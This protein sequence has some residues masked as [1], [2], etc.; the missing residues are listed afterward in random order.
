MEHVANWRERR[1]RSGVQRLNKE[2]RRHPP[3]R[4]ELLA[5]KL[6]WGNPGYSAGIAYLTHLC[7]AVHE[8]SGG[9]LECGSGLS[10]LVGGMLARQVGRPWIALENHGPSRRRMRRYLAALGL[11]GVSL[12]T[13]PIVSYGGYD[14]YGVPEEIVATID[15]DLVICDGPP[16]HTR[17]GRF[18]LMPAMGARL[19]P[20]CRILLDDAYRPAERNIIRRWR[21]LVDLEVRFLGRPLAYAEIILIT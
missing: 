7:R 5:L 12:V 1:L 9:I 15:I 20:G 17:G 19:R 10:T 21:D 2:G 13:A 16:W 8:N 18:G 4:C 11:D 14:W 6:W 3:S